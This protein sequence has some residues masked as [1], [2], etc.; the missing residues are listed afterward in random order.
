[1][2]GTCWSSSLIISLINSAAR[3]VSLF[4]PGRPSLPGGDQGQGR[5]D[6]GR[7]ACRAGE[8][9]TSRRGRRIALAPF[10]SLA[11]IGLSISRFDAH[12]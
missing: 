11:D 8:E 10:G 1:M 2:I 9:R 12:I 6:Q 4:G 5:H 7:G 3:P